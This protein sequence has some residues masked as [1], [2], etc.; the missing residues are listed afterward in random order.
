MSQAR[1]PWRRVSVI[2]ELCFATI[3]GRGPDGYRDALRAAARGARAGPAVNSGAVVHPGSERTAQRSRPRLREREVDVLL[4]G[5]AVNVRYLTGFTGTHGLALIAAAGA[6]SPGRPR[7][8]S[9]PISATP[10]SRPSR[11]RRSSSARSWPADLL[12]AVPRVAA[13]G[14]RAAGVRRGE[15][16]RRPALAASGAAG[17][18]V[19]ARAVRG[20]GRAPAGRQGRRRARAHPRRLRARR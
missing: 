4:V 5:T 16:H 17:G 13:R 6:G 8:G 18:D 7:I 10:R 14:R 19:G 9:S 15:P 3:S 20:R 2:G 12:E 11:C 1:E